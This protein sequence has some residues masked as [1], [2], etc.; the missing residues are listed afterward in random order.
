MKSH[1]E[2]RSTRCASV[3][4]GHDRNRRRGFDHTLQP[5]ESAI[6][7]SEDVVSIDAAF[8]M[9][10]TFAQDAP[11]VLALFDALVELLT[12]DERKGSRAA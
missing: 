9:R 8:A 12:G 1:T 3:D 5:H 4:L 7:P 10:A 2:S 11:A 6:D